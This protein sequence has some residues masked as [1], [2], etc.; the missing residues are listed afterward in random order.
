[1]KIKNLRKELLEIQFKDSI[2][3]FATELRTATIS[4]NI[5]IR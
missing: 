1:M 2:D 5:I 4:I 3:T